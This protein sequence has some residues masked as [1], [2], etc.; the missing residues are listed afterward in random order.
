M[1]LKIIAILSIV[2]VGIAISYYMTLLQTEKKQLP[3]IQPRD[4]KQEMVDPELI[5]KG[6]GHRIGKFEFT[7]QE[8]K[9]VTLD[10]VKGSVFVAEYFFTTCGTI[11]PKMTE[12]M[13]RVQAKF[14]GNNNVKI[15]SFTVNPEYDN[16][17]VM[18]EYADKYQAVD[19]QWHFLTGTKEA[20]YNL[21]RTSFFVL[22]P[23]EAANLGDAGSDFIHTN[24][25]V[26][27]DQQL[28]IRGYYDGTDVD[29]VSTLMNDIDLLLKEE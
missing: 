5:Q 22:K 27:V 18:R 16:V 24:N 7:N 10:D 1:K 21:A 3:I 23:A 4:V 28:R 11:C 14:K 8:G 13:T 9:K 2:V 17:D 26:L 6:I 29:E 20:L 25:F 19:G 12:Q 15:L